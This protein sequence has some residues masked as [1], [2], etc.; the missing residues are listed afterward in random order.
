MAYLPPVPSPISVCVLKQAWS[1][2]IIMI[3]A[4]LEFLSEET[5]SQNKVAFGHEYKTKQILRKCFKQAQN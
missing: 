1:T 5:A 4:Q 3:I 2:N